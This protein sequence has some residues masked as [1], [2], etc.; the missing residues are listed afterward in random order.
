MW[1]LRIQFLTDTQE[2][3]RQRGDGVERRL[4]NVAVN[5]F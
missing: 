1:L 4:V 5:H 3:D 2:H